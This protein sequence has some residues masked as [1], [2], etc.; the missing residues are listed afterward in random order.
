VSPVE[1]HSS[2]PFVGHLRSAVTAAEIAELSAVPV[3]LTGVFALPVGIREALVFSHAEPTLRTA[4]G[5]DFVHC[6]AGHLLANRVGYGLVVPMVCLPSVL[7][8]RRERF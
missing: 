6:G 4:F 5:A 2:E 3:L 7:S 8:G 1:G